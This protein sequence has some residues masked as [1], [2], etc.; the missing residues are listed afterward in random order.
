MWTNTVLLCALLGLEYCSQLLFNLAL[1]FLKIV[2]YSAPSN[3]WHD[4][5]I[6]N[7]L[8]CILQ[9]SRNIRVH[10]TRV[11]PRGLRLNRFLIHQRHLLLSRHF[12]PK[13]EKVLFFYSQ[14]KQQCSVVRKRCWRSGKPSTRNMKGWFCCDAKSTKNL[15]QLQPLDLA[16][17]FIL[18][19]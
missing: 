8:C 6:I 9:H 4:F 19:K 18:T 15:V 11:L 3:Q 7:A 12:Y 16:E 2:S 10:Q 1:E 17:Q 5:G 14:V 13:C